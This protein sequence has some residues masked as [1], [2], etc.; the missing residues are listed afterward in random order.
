MKLAYAFMG[1]LQESKRPGILVG[2]GAHKSRDRIM[3][4]A[5]KHRIPVFRTWNALDVATDDSP[6]YSG[7]IGTYGGPGRNFGVQN[8][9]LLLILGCRISGRITGGMPETFA[10]GAKTYRVDIEDGNDA[11][12]FVEHCLTR[13]SDWTLKFDAWLQKCI[14]W[15]VKYDPVKPE[16]LSE[17]HHYGVMRRLS[18][19]IP[20]NAI[21]TYDTGGNAIMMGHCFRSK[22]GQRIFSS[23]G[24]SPMGSAMCLAIGAWFADPARPIICIIGDG[25][26]Q[27]NI[28]ELQTIKHYGIPVKVFVFN[29]KVLGNTLSYIRVN[30]KA[31]VACDETSGYSSPDFVKVA[32]AYGIN[33]VSRDYWGAFDMVK[34]AL[35]LASPVVVDLIDEDRCQYEPRIS[36]FDIPIED[37]YPFLPR[38]EFRKNMYI[39]PHAGWENI[40]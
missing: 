23:N 27:L 10:R 24:N 40:K 25:G 7:T 2:G 29:N 4:F 35:G 3:A 11:G 34:W 32:E 12:E 17:W 14:A 16:H 38:D 36:R 28:Q 18:E 15:R 30:K 6:V 13:Y 37:A 8:C 19:Q 26:M 1:D 21:V 9:D 5:E 20:S 33:A 22:R 39:E 31:V